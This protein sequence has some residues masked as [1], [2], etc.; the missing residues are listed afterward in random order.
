MRKTGILARMMR[1]VTLMRSTSCLVVAALLMMIVHPGLVRA[2]EMPRARIAEEEPRPRPSN[3]E[4][5]VSEK[6]GR[7]LA[8]VARLE[9]ALATEP[10]TGRQAARVDALRKRLES[11]DREVNAGFDVVNAM[12]KK[13]GLPKVIQERQEETR[14]QYRER[15][16]ALFE[17]LSAAERSGSPEQRAQMLKSLSALAEQPAE[18]RPHQRLDPNNLPVNRP[19]GKVRKPAETPEEFQSRFRDLKVDVKASRQPMARAA[20]AVAPQ[21]ADLQPT[22][23][24]QITPEVQALASELGNSPLTIYNWVRDNVELVPT[25]G[26]I[27]GSR[28]TLLTKRGNAFDIATLLIALLRA[29]NVPARYVLGT[30]QVPA[31][32]LANWLGGTENPAVTQ[33]LLGQG[34]IPNVGLLQNGQTSHIRVEHVWVEAWV[35]YVPGRGA[36]PGPGD[37]WVPLD[38]SLKAHDLSPDSGLLAGIPFDMT[39]FTNAL[40]QNAQVDPLLGR[41]NG[42]DVNIAYDSVEDWQQDLQEYAAANSV[43]STEDALLGKTAIVPSGAKVLP[44]SLP[45]QVLV[46]AS[47]VSTL[48]AS[49]RLGVKLTG[50]ASNLD[51]AFGSPS[52]TYHVSLPALGNGRLGLT[53]PPATVADAQVI[54]TARN[55][56]ASSLPVY[57]INVKPSITL[58][59]ATVAGGAAVRM[60]SAYFVDVLLE[61][62]AGSAT[63]PY[64]VIAGDE[65]VIGLNGDGVHSA[66][67]QDRFNRVP[68]DT[69]VENMQQVALHYW[70]ECDA[71]D[72]LAAKGLKVHALRRFSVGLFSTPLNV[73]HLFGTP[74]SGIYQSRIMDVKRSFVGVAGLTDDLTRAFVRSSGRSGSFLEGSVFDQLFDQPRGRG[75]SAMQLLF[76]ASLGGIALYEVTSSNV[77]AVLPLLQVPA[78][79]KVD[80]STAVSQGKVVIV[81]ESEIQHDNYRGVGYIVEDPET[82]AAAYLISGGLAGGALIQCLLELV[83]VFVIILA[84]VLLAVLLWWLWP[85]IAAGLAGLAAGAGAGAPVTA[86]VVL[87]I[88]ALF[89]T[90]GS[91]QAS[92]GG[93]GGGGGAGPCTCP[94]CPANPPCE[95]DVSHTHWPCIDPADHWHFRVYN[96]VP[97]PDCRCFLS[98]RQFGGCIPPPLPVPCPP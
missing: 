33:Q 53:F 94:P 52:F 88:V 4:A 63:V 91:A 83:P 5:S 39:D 34:G 36:K 43:P 7:T 75:V 68:S 10:D 1:A 16:K 67:V 92:T 46:R 35:D 86:S 61:D 47:A 84:I 49:L 25:Y 64:Q 57:L 76:D 89:V 3:I 6:L 59:G 78:A 71:L 95:V 62:P 77:A 29:S 24:V 30:V 9:K 56:N 74:R 80:I 66:A 44:A 87:A 13:D 60:G 82:G 21:P 2:Q 37:T 45:Y 8:E 32:K 26:S 23:D 27:K 42:I 40:L 28:M 50:Y 51:R 72:A 54:E 18:E 48:P 93:G 19:A 90:T 98:G 41:V 11:L 97:Y 14:Q 96:Q 17:G 12:L 55:N 31:D 38:A 65:A 15:M 20:A 79:V 70:A 69:A 22:E 81:S 85:F 58:D 73:A